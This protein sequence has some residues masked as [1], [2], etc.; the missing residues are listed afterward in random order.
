M[1]RWRHLMQQTSFLSGLICV[2][3][4]IGPITL[5]AQQPDSSSQNPPYI[6][7]PEESN[8]YN[9]I[10]MAGMMAAMMVIA[11]KKPKRAGI[12]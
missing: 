7:L 6:K 3:L 12:H 4:L 1:I 9:Y 8:T 10:A 2:L 11:F 5:C